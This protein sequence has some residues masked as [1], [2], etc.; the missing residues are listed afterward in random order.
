MSIEKVNLAIELMQNSG[1]NIVSTGGASDELILNTETRLGIKFPD[2]YM[3]FLKKYGSLFFTGEMFYGLTRSG[4]ESESVPCVIFATESAR[5]L[6]EVSNKMIYIK[7]SGYGPLFCLDLENICGD[8][9]VI[10]VSNSNK[11]DKDT[12]IIADS[13]GDFFYNEIK[14]AVQDT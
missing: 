3:Y 1:E 13:F 14:L 2:D 7:D 8:T 6:G 10:E 11:A 9:P 5:K 12:I 4:L